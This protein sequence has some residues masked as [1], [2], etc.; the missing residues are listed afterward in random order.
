MSTK[1]LPIPVEED[2]DASIDQAVSATH[3]CK[4]DVIR[5]AL[6]FG[7]PALSRLLAP[8]TGNR[9]PWQEYIDDY[10]PAQTV[11]SGYKAALKSKLKDK[12]ARNC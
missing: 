11:A 12:Y 4:L 5:Q 2:I 8:P 6:R 3:L 9:Q 10:S 7:V 1:T